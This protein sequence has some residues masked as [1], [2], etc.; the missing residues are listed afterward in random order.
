MP[1]GS[2]V[3][4]AFHTSYAGG[5]QESQKP[6][7]PAQFDFSIW[8]QMS[9]LIPVLQNSSVTHGSSVTQILNTRT[10]TQCPIVIPIDN[11]KFLG[12]PKREN[13]LLTGG[14]RS[15][16]KVLNIETY[17]RKAM[18]AK[19]NSDQM[20]ILCPSAMSSFSPIDPTN[21]SYLM[22][23][24]KL[25]MTCSSLPTSPQALTSWCSLKY[26]STHDVSFSREDK[27]MKMPGMASQ[28][29]LKWFEKLS[30]VS[31]RPGLLPLQTPD[32]A[33]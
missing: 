32:L 13:F 3:Q 31:T 2:R 33:A 7:Q 24:W 14:R 26:L 28:E 21:S 16:Q 18:K 1:C 5:I 12:S 30:K 20:P 11:E 23:P 22:P 25:G 8:A 19:K 15:I 10:L 29:S 17:L 4:L 27:T 6:F 9:N